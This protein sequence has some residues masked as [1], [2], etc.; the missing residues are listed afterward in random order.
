MGLMQLVQPHRL[1]FLVLDAH[2]VLASRLDIAK[3]CFCWRLGLCPRAWAMVCHPII[4]VDLNT[5]TGARRLHPDLLTTLLT[6]W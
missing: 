6:P 1:F 4:H 3:Y 5:S 2:C